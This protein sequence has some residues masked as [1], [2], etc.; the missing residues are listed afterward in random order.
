MDLLKTNE[1]IR[2]I[3]ELKNISQEFVANELGITT[4][5]YS[6]IETGETQLTI[7]RLDK[8]CKILNV[9]PQ[10]LLG[11]DSALIFNNNFNNEHNEGY[12]QAFNNTDI[13]QVKE[14]Y[15]RLLD[16]KD[17]IIKVLENQINQYRN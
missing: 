7:N 4:R 3:R 9:S 10:E 12:Q 14:L 15:E 5:A 13:L 1:N 11:F 17:K 2:K 16:E 8:I 6:K